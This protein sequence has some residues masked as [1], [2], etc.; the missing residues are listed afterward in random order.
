LLI[1][2][3]LFTRNIDKN[4]LLSSEIQSAMY[5]IPTLDTQEEVLTVLNK[6]QSCDEPGT[7]GN[8]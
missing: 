7:E 2:F 8:C 1:N 5:L 3:T 4:K 6:I